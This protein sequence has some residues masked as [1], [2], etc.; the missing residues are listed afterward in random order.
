MAFF[1]LPISSGPSLPS[2]QPN[3]VLPLSSKTKQKQAKNNTHTP[4]K[5]EIKIASKRDQ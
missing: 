2:Y 5:P 1:S 4:R 3:F